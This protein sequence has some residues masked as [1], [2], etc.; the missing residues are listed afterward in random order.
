MPYW[1]GGYNSYYSP[2]YSSGSSNWSDCGDGS[3]GSTSFYSGPGDNQNV[4]GVRFN[5]HVPPDARVFFD[6][7][8]TNQS[9]QFRQF[10]AAPLEGNGKGTYEIR[11]SWSENGRPAER[12]RKVDVHNGQVVNL[13]FLTADQSGRPMPKA[14][15]DRDQDRYNAPAPERS[16]H[17]MPE[18]ER[19]DQNKPPS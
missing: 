12:T 18:P 6:G 4:N 3:Q 11:A 5:V 16:G 10:V 8:P 14:D 7:E 17:Q 9:G 13:D 2:G 19:T 1:G 15:Q